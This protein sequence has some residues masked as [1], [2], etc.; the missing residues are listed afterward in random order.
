[1]KTFALACLF[2]LAILGACWI[3]GAAYL[4]LLHQL[5]APL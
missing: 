3:T 4:F 2:A 1:M 5:G